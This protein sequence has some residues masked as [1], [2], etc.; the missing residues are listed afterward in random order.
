MNQVNIMNKIPEDVVGHI[1]SFICDKRGYHYIDYKRRKRKNTF[2]MKRIL[3][4]LILFH[5][6]YGGEM[7]ILKPNRTQGEK[8]K[9]F[10]NNLKDGKPIV[11]YHTGLYMNIHWERGWI[12]TMWE[13]EEK[14]NSEMRYWCRSRLRALGPHYVDKDN[15]RSIFFEELLEKEKNIWQDTYRRIV[16]KSNSEADKWRSRTRMLDN[17]II[18]SS[19]KWNQSMAAA[20]N[21]L[22]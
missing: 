20:A 12:K 7:R 21:S 14:K 5:S 13:L 18:E 22:L 2:R 11:N 17:N 4:E 15:G 8:R 19:K 10:L 16:N 6:D 9:T 1:I 3:A